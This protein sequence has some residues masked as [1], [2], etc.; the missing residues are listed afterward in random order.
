MLRQQ[1]NVFAP[2]A[3]RGQVNL[4]HVEAVI[5]VLSESLLSHFLRQVFVGGS[6]DSHFGFDFLSASQAIEAALL[7]HAQQIG[8]Q[9][10]RDIADF[11]EEK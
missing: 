5:E 4:N 1:G 2:L 6:D 3:Q 10:G 11:I 9:F 8:L 7:Q